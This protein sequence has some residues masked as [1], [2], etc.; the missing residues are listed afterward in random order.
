VVHD[1]DTRSNPDWDIDPADEP[2]PMSRP[3]DQRTEDEILKVA[4][5]RGDLGPLTILQ[6][7]RDAG[8]DV[9][10]SEVN[11]VLHRY[12]LPNRRR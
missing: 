12:N 8:L 2:R 1:D 10:E 4:R 3:R 6:Q 5:K 7:L 11:D 9:E